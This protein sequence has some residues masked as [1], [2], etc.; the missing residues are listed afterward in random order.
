MEGSMSSELF[1]QI[2]HL[3]EETQF[4][5]LLPFLVEHSKNSGVMATQFWAGGNLVNPDPMIESINRH[6]E[7]IKMICERL[8]EIAF[9]KGGV[10]ETH[11]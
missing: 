6:E 10:Y 7:S 3:P 11:Y 1:E 2:K 5:I 8:R 9:M 4:E